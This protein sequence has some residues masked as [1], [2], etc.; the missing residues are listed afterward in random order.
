[1]LNKKQEEAIN[2]VDTCEYDEAL[3]T[4][5][6]SLIANYDVADDV[7]DALNIEEED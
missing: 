5:L 3:K 6:I 2:L 4:I 7:I 1:M